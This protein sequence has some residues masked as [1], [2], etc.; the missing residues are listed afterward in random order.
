MT[1]TY[2]PWKGRTFTQVSTAIQLNKNNATILKPNQLRKALPLQ[3]FRRELAVYGAN[4]KDISTPP[5]FLSNRRISNKIDYINMPGSTVI[6]S[7]SKSPIGICDTVEFTIPNNTTELPGMCKTNCTNQTCITDQAC[8]ARKRVRSAGMIKRVYNSNKMVPSYCAN[9]S[10]YL[11]S[12]NLSYSTNE[13]AFLRKGNPSLT[14]GPN[15][16]PT[17]IYTTGGLST[18]DYINIT[19]NNNTFS[20]VWINGNTYTVTIPI[21]SYKFD[22]FVSAFNAQLF[23]NGTY[24][25]NIASVYNVQLLTIGYDNI[26]NKVLLQSA[27]A[28]NAT[29]INKF[30]DNTNNVTIN[31]ADITRYMPYFII[32]N[33][34]IQ[35]ILG[36][37]VGDYNYYDAKSTSIPS[38]IQSTSNIPHS[39]YPTYTA[40][41]YK[42]SNSKF[43]QQG[44]VSASARLLRKKYDTITTAANTLRT[45]LGIA[46][47]NAM[48]YGVSEDP[49]TVKDQLGYPNTKYPIST[50]N[51]MTCV[52]EK[53]KRNK[54]LC[55]MS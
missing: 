4:N 12:R 3:I 36:F 21:G 44:A 53:S 5:S 8:N 22:S 55:V 24:L 26:N 50:N 52:S 54:N 14:P 41:N 19:A 43:A 40:M 23:I 51:K 42:P 13:F 32:P 2:F 16:A 45:P 35:N 47:A 33:T 34:G 1:R 29:Y 20:Y 18:C 37:S 7:K 11:I 39:I 15:A 9:T 38:S 28:N 48:S 25:V 10:Q 27:N 6:S 46:A 30:K 49:Y 17:N 31:T